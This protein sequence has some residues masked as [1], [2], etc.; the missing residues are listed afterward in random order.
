MLYTTTFFYFY[1]YYYFIIS[2]VP[3]T[4]Y[5]RRHFIVASYTY[6]KD[7]PFEQSKMIDDPKEKFLQAQDFLTSGLLHGERVDEFYPRF[8]RRSKAVILL[9]RE[10]TNFTI[11]ALKILFVPFISFNLSKIAP[12]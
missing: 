11:R 3:S 5:P 12:S 1:C 7:N 9:S 8:K 6:S 4:F 2:P 10:R